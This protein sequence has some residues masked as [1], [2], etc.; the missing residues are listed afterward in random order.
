[1][2]GAW[3]KLEED[4]NAHPP[5]YIVVLQVPAKNARYPVKDFPILAKL[6]AD[7]Y[8]PVARTAEGAIYQA[9]Q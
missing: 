8:K 6:L 1:V 5:S 7:R 3:E 2:P 9:S 4:F